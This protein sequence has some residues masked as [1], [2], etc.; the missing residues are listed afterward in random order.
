MMNGSA[1]PVFSNDW[2][3]RNAKVP[4]IGKIFFMASELHAHRG[5]ASGRS[6]DFAAAAD[7]KSLFASRAL[8]RHSFASCAELQVL[9][10]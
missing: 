9:Q 5:A 1:A 6:G 10:H 2:K 4:M 7:W 8:V 3:K